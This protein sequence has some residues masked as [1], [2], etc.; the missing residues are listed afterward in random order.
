MESEQVPVA[1][2]VSGGMVDVSVG[3]TTVELGELGDS[4]EKS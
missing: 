2:G 1:V 4:D 3:W